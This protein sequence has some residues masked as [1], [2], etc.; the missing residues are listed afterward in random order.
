MKHRQIR[1]IIFIVVYFVLTVSA[2]SQN[3]NEVE[4]KKPTYAGFFAFGG[5]GPAIPRGDFGKERDAGF[6]LNTAISYQFPS[7][8]MI[9]GMFDFSSFNFKRGA[10]TQTVGSETY[11]LSGSNNLISLNVSGGYY[12]PVGR[13]SPYI[14]TGIGVSFISKPEVEVDENLNTIDLT[15]GLGTYFSTVSGIGID[16]LVN[17]PKETDKEDKTPFILYMETFYT[18]VPSDTDVSQHKF[19]LLTFNVGI[20][21][22]M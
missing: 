5:V 9:R 17:P 11:E 18:Y 2:S 14:F 3:T 8:L 4:V 20:K 13:F 15:L 16:F 19:Q 6:D 12:I 1:F 7:R 21:T 10:I 22:K